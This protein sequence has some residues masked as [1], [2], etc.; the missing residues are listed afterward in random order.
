MDLSRTDCKD[1]CIA[2]IGGIIGA[3]AAG[4]AIVPS[5]LV[6]VLCAAGMLMVKLL[7][8]PSI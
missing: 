6:S 4:L 3:L 2:L 8:K 7:A 1:V 5:I